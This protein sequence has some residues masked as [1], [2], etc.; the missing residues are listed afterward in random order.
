[1]PCECEMTIKTLS[2]LKVSFT[3][4]E[5]AR[6]YARAI[7][8][9]WATSGGTGRGKLEHLIALA[10]RGADL[11]RQQPLVRGLQWLEGR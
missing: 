10:G 5:L 1:M 3:P 8:G 9:L 2:E 4:Q 11:V 6:Q 7:A